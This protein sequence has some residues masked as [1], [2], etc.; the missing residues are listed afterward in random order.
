MAK[1]LSRTV[2]L[3]IP[4]VLKFVAARD[5]ASSPE[6]LRELQDRFACGH[7]AAQDALGVL[8]GGGWLERR[9][10]LNDRRRKRY[11]VTELGRDDLVTIPGHR[12]M[13]YARRSYSTC[14]TKAET[15]P[16][17]CPQPEHSFIV[18]PDSA[19]RRVPSPLR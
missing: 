10:D 16:K 14:S 8:V 7:R 6:L 15:E 4:Q 3:D 9:N 17:S 19:A 1:A 12:A 13:R 18:L 11:F 5:G 2:K